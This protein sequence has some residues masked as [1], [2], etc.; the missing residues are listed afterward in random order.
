MERIEKSAVVKALAADESELERINKQALR[1]LKGEEVFAFR[2]AAC[3]NQVDR[4]LERF[5][6]DTLEELAKLFVGKPVLLDHQWSA[7]KQVA[8]IYAAGTEGEGERLRLILRCYMP[9]NEA[10]AAVIAAIEAGLL[11]ECSVGCAVEKAVC[12]ICGSDKARKRC[13]HTPGQEYDGQACHV[14]LSGARDAYEVSFCAVPCQREAGVVKKYGGED[15]P[16]DGD[17]APGGQ[18]TAAPQEEAEIGK[19]LALLELERY[20]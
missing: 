4:D 10:T 20:A 7:E 2:L 5:T 6:E 8:R 9:R 18:G 19:A 15:A 1:P 13:G 11:R 14:E 12:S 17:G 3:D 16:E